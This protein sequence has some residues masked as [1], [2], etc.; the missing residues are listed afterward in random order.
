MIVPDSSR[1]GSG[2]EFPSTFM[3]HPPA[4][5][6]HIVVVGYGLCRQ[7]TV[8]GCRGYKGNGTQACQ[9]CGHGFGMHY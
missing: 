8:D 2:C 7:W 1:T 5:R 3:G 4:L 6:A 9:D